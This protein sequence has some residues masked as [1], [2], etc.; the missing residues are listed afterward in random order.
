MVRPELS[1]APTD[2]RTLE[3]CQ[4]ATGHS[5]VT[6]IIDGQLLTL[7]GVESREAGEAFTLALIVELT[8]GHFIEGAVV[9]AKAVS[10]DHPTFL[11]SPQRPL[12]PR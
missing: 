10:A 3:D 2:L 8:R 12:N 9:H 7:R 11:S 5:E 4:E 6:L 1:P